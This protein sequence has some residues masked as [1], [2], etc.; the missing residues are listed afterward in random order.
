MP[1]RKRTKENDA[2]KIYEEII[3]NNIEYEHFIKHM[4]MDMDKD[5]L[6]E[7]VSMMLETVCARRK[8]I[9]IAGNDYRQSLSKGNL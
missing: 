1:E 5:R 2:Y 7:I 6:D 8:K 3:K 4:D 9:C